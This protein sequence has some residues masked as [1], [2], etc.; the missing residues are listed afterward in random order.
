[1]NRR[2]LLL[3]AGACLIARPALAAPFANFPIALTHVLK[4]EGGYV[5]HPDDPGGRT[6]EGV[7]QKVYDGWRDR[8]GLPR[9]LLTP[10]MRGTAEWQAERNAIY[11]ELYWDPIGGD[12]LPRGVDYSLFDY[13]VHSGVA[14]AGKVA[15]CL[16]VTGMEL[17]QCIATA[18]TYEVTDGVLDHL[19][20]LDPATVIR[21][22]WDE[23]GRF[24]ARLIAARPASK[25]F[26]RGWANRRASGRAIALTMA[27][28]RRGNV[29]ALRALPGP[30]KAFD[31]DE[32]LEEAM[33]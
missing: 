9:R 33:P 3:G 25:A 28:A 16:T 29:S 20:R 18:R 23:R 5:F 1:M 14:R 26:E 7:T 31:P 19:N 13:A 32:Q 21:A 8:Q 6:L 12:A 17:D 22:I 15:R 2:Q 30:G 27:G 11:R 4:H 10:A 24:H